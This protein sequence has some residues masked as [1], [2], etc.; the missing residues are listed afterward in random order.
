MK[1]CAVKTKGHH[2]IISNYIIGVLVWYAIGFGLILTD[3]IYP[4][5]KNRVKLH[6]DGNVYQAVSDL[7]E[8]KARNDILMELKD[9]DRRKKFWEIYYG[10]KPN[11][12]ITLVKDKVTIDSIAKQLQELNEQQRVLQNILGDINPDQFDADETESNDNS[13]PHN[14]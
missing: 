1:N 2:S 10:T 6:G 3:N 13:I 5:S 8:H 7:Y 9:K 12:P 11:H 4:R 14:D